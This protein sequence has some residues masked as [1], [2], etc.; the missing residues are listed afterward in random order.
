MSGII[1]LIIQLMQSHIIMAFMSVIYGVWV[2]IALPHMQPV[3]Q[4]SK[5][6]YDD[7][8]CVGIGINSSAAAAAAAV[9]LQQCLPPHCSAFPHFPLL[10]ITLVSLHISFAGNFFTLARLR[11]CARHLFAFSIPLFSLLI[12]G[13]H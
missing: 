5:I 4:Q 2:A 8:A 9:R 3:N 7:F 10:I 13:E 1:N 6:N 11:V 12:C